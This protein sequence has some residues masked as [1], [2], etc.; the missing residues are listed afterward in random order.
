MIILDKGLE[1]IFCKW[2][3]SNFFGFTGHEVSVE[4]LNSSVVV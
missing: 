4:I 1:N 2:L 3:N